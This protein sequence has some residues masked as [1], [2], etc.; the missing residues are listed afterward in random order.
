MPAGSWNVELV[1]NLFTSCR[2]ADI[3]FYPGAIG[4]QNGPEKGLFKTQKQRAT[5]FLSENK[6]SFSF[7]I[8]YSW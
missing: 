3:V 6:V 1:T 7:N 4:F 8:D 5:S 2:Y